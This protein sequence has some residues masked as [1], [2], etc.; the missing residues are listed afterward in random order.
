MPDDV[1]ERLALVMREEA[2]YILADGSVV[3]SQLYEAEVEWH[4]QWRRVLAASMDGGPLV[5]MAMLRGSNL[6]VDVVTGGRVAIR[7]L[8]GSA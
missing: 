1:I 6:S 8:T 4:G 5:G 7:A 2:E 3:V